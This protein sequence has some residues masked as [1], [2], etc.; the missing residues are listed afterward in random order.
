VDGL[1]GRPI[2]KSAPADGQAL[3]W[4]DRARAW[5][6]QGVVLDGEVAQIDVTGN[7][8]DKL[9]VSGILGRTIEAPNPEDMDEIIQPGS[10]I[11]WQS[12]EGRG[13]GHWVVQAPSGSELPTPGGDVVGS[14]EDL[15][16]IGIRGKEIV[17]DPEPT[18]GQVLQFDGRRWVPADLP[19]TVPTTPVVVAAGY[20]RAS[21]KSEVPDDP[22]A[23]VNIGPVFGELRP[24]YFDTAD[25][26]FIELVFKDYRQ[27]FVPDDFGLPPEVFTHMYIVKGHTVDVQKPQDRG[28][29]PPEGFFRIYSNSDPSGL[30]TFTTNGILIK[31]V[32]RGGGPFIGAFM[33][34]VTLI[35]NIS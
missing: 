3:I 4:I 11:V 31:L 33:I 27:P 21:G 13:T 32:D 26:R 29:S 5:V 14:L 12:G 28:S 10:L 8:P 19:S 7:Y 20:F 9:I 23:I 1:R 17:E 30:G 15:K 25:A 35:L 2:S 22:N 6:P 34:E 24:R 18:R 16:V